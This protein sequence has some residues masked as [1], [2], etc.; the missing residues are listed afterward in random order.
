MKNSECIKDSHEHW[1]FIFDSLKPNFLP[2][3][4]S[5]WIYPPWGFWPKYLLLHLISPPNRKKFAKKKSYAISMIILMC[6][7][8]PLGQFQNNFR[9]FFSPWGLSRDHYWRGGIQE[10][11]DFRGLL[12]ISRRVYDISSWNLFL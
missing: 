8:N 5:R 7:Q 3:F 1:L 10:S 11:H 12:R 2:I 6:N 9:N 4:F